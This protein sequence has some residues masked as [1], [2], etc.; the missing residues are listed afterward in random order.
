MRP[1]NGEKIIRRQKL[2]NG[3]EGEEEGASAIHVVSEEGG[4]GGGVGVG[5]GGHDGQLDVK[6]F[7]RVGPE[8][9]AH[10][11]EGRRLAESIDSLD[12][13]QSV[14]LCD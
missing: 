1:D 2:A 4:R 8:E 11:A 14:D 6:V 10:G 9:V 3:V 5:R 12:V 13:G 7:L